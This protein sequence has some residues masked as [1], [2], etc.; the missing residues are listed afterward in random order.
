MAVSVQPTSR[1]SSR[2]WR[3]FVPGLGVKRYVLLLSLGLMILVIGFTQFARM[4]PANRFFNTIVIMLSEVSRGGRLPLWTLGVG[5]TTVGAVMVSLGVVGLNR[6]ILR[7][8]GTAP[9]DT[10]DRMFVARALH[11]GPRIV[12]IGGGTGLSN[13]LAGLKRYSAN[14]TGIVAV[15][16]DGGSSGRLREMLG[17]PAPG[18]LTDCY[19]AL[20]D[21]PILASLL[22]HRFERGAGLEGH[23]FGNL[24]LATLSEERGFAQAT[25]A[26]NEILNVR[27]S[28]VPATSQPVV[29]LSELSD[30][31]V[32]RGESALRL[33]KRE[34]RVTRARLEP[35]NPPAM[36]AALEAISDAELIVI[37]PGSLYTS[38]IPPLLVPEVAAAI[39]TSSARVA[40]VAN[41]MTEAGETDGMDALEHVRVLETH[42]GRKPDVIV[43]NNSRIPIETLQRYR[44]EHAEV[45]QV[46][47]SAL[48]R[49]GVEVYPASLAV[50][51]SAQHD[52][53]VL[54]LA[55]VRLLAERRGGKGFAWMVLNLAKR[56]G[57][58]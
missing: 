53:R 4:G 55:L 57:R 13:L 45:V 44:L 52:P 42:L 24:L 11:R 47:E 3:W 12:A 22:T 29:L 46:D 43:I 54:A 9:E 28:V 58:N 50:D 35:A 14:L 39:R 41:I 25:L 18:D 5:L 6:S 15:T 27:G 40:Y 1:K 20:S 49:A 48:E 23:T 21:S 2:R 30:G 51:G 8:M 10:L 17:M 26:V 19:A 31:R 37:G 32:V 16:D 7:A 36:Q 38:V 56:I 34:Q 33:E